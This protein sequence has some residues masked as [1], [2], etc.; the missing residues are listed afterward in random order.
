[1]PEYTARA[2][3][4]PLNAV[5]VHTPG[6]ELWSGALDPE[7]NLFE[8]PMAPERARRE[9]ERLIE[10]YES[11]GVEVHTLA[12]DLATAG[13]LDELVR[14]YVTIPEDAA[15]DLEATLSALGPHEKLGL[16]LSR[17]RLER[18][19]DAASSVHVE[20]PISN[21]YFQ[22]DTTILGDKGPI[23][24]SMAKPV[25]QPEIPIVR[26]A[27]EGIGAE[28]VHEAAVGPI[29]G[30]EF[31]PMGE[32]A[33][34]GVSALVDG[35]EE[36]IR[37]SYDAGRS[38]LE[39]GAVGYDEFGLVRAPLETERQIRRGRGGESRLM[40]LLGWFNVAAEGLA[41][42]FEE[43]AEA[44]TVDVYERRGGS[45]RKTRTP[46][47]LEYLDGKGYDVIGADWAERWPTNFVAVDDG[48]IV[49]LYEP[50][51]DGEYR[52]ENNPTIEALKERGVT[53]LPGGEG[54][55]TGALTNGAG[56]FHCMTTPVSRGSGR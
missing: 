37:T 19:P 27:W 34:L 36:V 11:A 5:R 29:E 25:R 24:C 38:L 44:A 1:M 53:V 51:E 46:T 15:V 50:D 14:E 45:Y 12:D 56:G 7:A 28:V 3:F 4:D 17:A 6:P 9:H 8:G 22:R 23:L 32:F 20:R 33:L 26:E 47:L 52:P 13:V 35:E 54:L 49:P 30:G 39:A 40:H 43:L 55:P 16:A 18:H 31:M 2:E 10:T 48:E 41:V 42:A 21:I